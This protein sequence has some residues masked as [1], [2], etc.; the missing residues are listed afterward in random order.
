MLVVCALGGIAASLALAQGL[1]VPVPTVSVPT[2]SV[3]SVTVPSTTV[4]SVTVPPP[5]VSPPAPVPPPPTVQTPSVQTPST[6]TPSVQGSSAGAVTG[7]QGSSGSTATGGRSSSSGGAGSSSSGLSSA[8]GSGVGTT[9]GASQQRVHSTRPWIA[10]LG[11]KSR[12]TTIFKFRLGRN[13]IVE[14][15]V[16]QVSPVCRVVGRFRVRGHAGLN[17][18]QFN[19]RVH[20]VQLGAGTYR[21]SAR[22]RGAG[23]VLRTTIVVVGARTPSKAELALARR[24]NVCRAAGVLDASSIW[25]SFS[26]AAGDGQAGNQAR[27][28]IVRHQ[29]ESGESSDDAAP[30][31]SDHGRPIAEALSSAAGKA[32]NPVVIALLAMAAFILGLAALPRTA[33]ADPRVMALVAEHRAALTAA[34]TAAL[35][36]AV[37]AMLLA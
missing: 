20:G 30:S 1:P 33:V 6:Q 35:G 2:V 15:T 26:A 9:G 18:V 36:A 32:A 12:R 11:S 16:L 31:G 29:R 24:S 8:G 5:P 10:V 37:V 7:G 13:A 25:G 3:P 22:T 27:S 34:G 28:T 17:R 14:F 23:A 19:G 21:I 4:P